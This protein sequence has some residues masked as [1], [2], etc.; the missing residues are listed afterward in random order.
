M[1]QQNNTKFLLTGFAI[2]LLGMLGLIAVFFFHINTMMKS[3]QINDDLLKKNFAAYQMR[4][5]AEKR[6]FSLFRVIALDDYFE[7]DQIRLNMD[8][9]AL[10]FMVAQSQ[11]DLDALSP[12]EKEALDDI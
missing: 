2:I 11:L 5:A 4:E 10:D 8:R 1:T 7:R 12:A 3:D 9:Y 6:T